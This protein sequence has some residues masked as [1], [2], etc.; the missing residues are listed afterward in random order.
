[1]KENNAI[2]DKAVKVMME[3]DKTLT[4]I[5]NNVILEGEVP[6]LECKPT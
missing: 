1:M 5:Q 6:E 2:I 3:I 4:F